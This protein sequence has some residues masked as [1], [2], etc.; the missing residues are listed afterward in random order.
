MAKPAQDKPAGKVKLT[1]AALNVLRLLLD[2]DLVR[3]QGEE[4]YVRAYT[5]SAK[6]R[7]HPRTMR[8]LEDNSLAKKKD[9]LTW[10]GFATG[11]TSLGRRALKESSK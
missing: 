5:S 8:F 2:G 3:L 1:K 9:V 11:I 10:S 7:I 4:N 6:M